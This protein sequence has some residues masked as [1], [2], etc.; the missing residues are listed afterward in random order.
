[1]I[2]NRKE[3]NKI[4]QAK[5][6]ITSLVNELNDA[7]YE[8]RISWEC[9]NCKIENNDLSVLHQKDNVVKY[10]FCSKDN[11]ISSV[12]LTVDKRNNDYN[13]ELEF[14]D[15]KGV[16]YE[17]P[18]EDTCKCLLKDLCE[19]IEDDIELSVAEKINSS[20]PTLIQTLQETKSVV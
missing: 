18:M 3:L 1:M 16:V 19:V 20:I 13:L 6:R 17:V 8:H 4:K 12:Y 2:D 11:V 7:T 15:K 14:A 10:Q 9:I 5:E